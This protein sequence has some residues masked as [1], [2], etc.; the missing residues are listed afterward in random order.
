[1][2]ELSRKNE[3]RVRK[4]AR[5]LLR[6]ARKG[7]RSYGYKL[8]DSIKEQ[9]GVHADKLESA[10]GHTDEANR[11]RVRTELAVLDD[12]VDRN[13]SFARKSTGREYGESIGIAILIAL[14]LRAFVIEAFKIPSTSMIPTMEIGDHIF[15]NKFLYGVRLP[16]T[17]KR[18]LDVRA[19]KPGE[20]I[21]FIY[22]CDPDKDFIKRVV[23]VEGDSVEV[24]CDQVYVNGSLREQE[25]V[26]TAECSYWDTMPGAP[27]G[28]GERHCS[29]YR[30]TVGDVSYDTVYEEM[31]PREDD[32]RAENPKG[33]YALHSGGQDF[34]GHSIPTCRDSSDGEQRDLDE[35]IAATGQIVS[36]DDEPTDV[37]GP[38]RHF[39]VPKDHVFV[40]GDNRAN[41]SDSRFWGPVPVK[42]IKGKALFIWW[43]KQPSEAGGLRLDRM[44]QMVH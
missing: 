29:L 39:I 10:L 1:M 5:G 36:A 19:P 21:V 17:T 11:G 22:P 32:M 13:L 9:I 27:T 14:L 34:P 7:L 30:E 41:S 23:A 40:M 28:W 18:I 38:R 3:R 37:C 6:N 25:Y 33:Q 16:Y 35:R 12:L 31:R 20:V 4:E 8:S 42:N 44:G 26:D 24:R 2:G 15:V 43:S